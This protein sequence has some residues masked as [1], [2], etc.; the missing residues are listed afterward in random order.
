MALVVITGGVR[1]GKSAAAQRLALL[2]ARDG[3]EVIVA[4][5]GRGSDA[6]M[7]DR[8][9][10][11]RSERPEDFAT[12]EVGDPSN[13]ITQIDDA[14][15]LV[16][17]CLG[18]LLGLVM[19]RAWCE[20]GDGPLGDAVAGQLPAG[21]ESAVVTEFDALVENIAARPGDTVVVT[22]EVGL[23]VVPSWASGRL[24]RDL[25]GRGNRR[26]VSAADA[27]Y[28]CV[29]GRMIDLTDQPIAAAWPR[30]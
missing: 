24:F 17:D 2:R 15:L 28:L 3:A 14:A 18:T 16:V 29:C 13:W 26:L 12:L 25:L 7:A 23:G 4:V 22:N 27:A 9:A 10:R 1:S 5:F 30:D 8:I 11:H 20:F 21:L 6:E 19:E